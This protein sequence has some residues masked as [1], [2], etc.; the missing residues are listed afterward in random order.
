MA[1]KDYVVERDFRYVDDKET[2][3]RRDAREK[4]VPP[5]FGLNAL[6]SAGAL[7]DFDRFSQSFL[8]RVKQG[9]SDE[10]VIQAMLADFPAQTSRA[11]LRLLLAYRGCRAGV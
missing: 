10:K 3:A 7:D 2:E 1:Q 8:Q 9:I 6:V 11:D 4:L 5:V